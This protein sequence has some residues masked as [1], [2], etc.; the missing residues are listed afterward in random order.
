MILKGTETTNVRRSEIACV[1]KI[2]V[3]P[4]YE[5]RTT[6]SGMKNMPCLQEARNV[7]GATKPRH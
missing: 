1:A 3:R 2:P 4:R 6:M 7:A 5:G